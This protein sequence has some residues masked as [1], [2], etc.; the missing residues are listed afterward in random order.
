MVVSLV[1]DIKDMNYLF[2]LIVWIKGGLSFDVLIVFID[3]IDEIVIYNLIYVL[4]DFFLYG[5]Y[6]LVMSLM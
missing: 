3:R 2:I 1:Y 5:I 6:E 4:V